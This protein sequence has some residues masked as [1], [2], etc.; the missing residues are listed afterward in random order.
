MTRPLCQDLYDKTSGVIITISIISWWESRSLDSWK[1][2]RYIYSIGENKTYFCYVDISVSLPPPLFVFRVVSRGKETDI[3]D[4]TRVVHL[5]AGD[6]E[7]GSQ[8]WKQVKESEGWDQLSTLSLDLISFIDKRIS[9]HNMGRA[10]TKETQ[11][12]SRVKVETSHLDRRSTRVTLTLIL[13]FGSFYCSWVSLEWNSLS[14]HAIFPLMK[15]WLVVVKHESICIISRRKD[16][17]SATWL[18][19]RPRFYTYEVCMC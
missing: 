4:K 7:G 16:D 18:L 12:S 2:H 5:T 19:T 9:N 15:R 8:E 6:L 17:S 3:N 13:F 10:V 1:M 14:L 11:V